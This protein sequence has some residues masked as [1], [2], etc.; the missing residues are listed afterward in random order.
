[1][2][3]TRRE[4]FDTLLAAA[5]AGATTFGTRP[6][7]A[8]TPA[9]RSPNETLRVGVIG[10]RGRGRAHIGAFKGMPNVEVAAICDADQSVVDQARKSV[11]DAVYHQDMR[12]LIEDD[13]LDI[14]AIATPNHWHSLATIWALQAGKHVYVEK[15][16]SHD[17]YEGRAVVEIA[18]ASG[19]V[20]QHGTQARTAKATR[21]AMQFLHEG[22]IGEVKLAR[23]LCYKRRGSI[24]QVGGAQEPP[25]S[26]D[27]KLWCGPAGMHPLTRRNLHYDWHWNFATGNGDLGN[28]G[29]HQMDI[30]RWGLGVDTLPTAIQSVGG[31]VGYV[32][33]GNTPNTQVSL[34]DYGA[35]QLIF[36]VRGLKTPGYK[37]ASIGV[38]FEGETGYLVSASYNK[39]QAFDHDGQ[40][41]ATFEGGE[42]HF[43][44]FIDAVRANDAA[45]VNASPLD[46]HLSSALC[47]LGNVSYLLGEAKPVGKL[48]DG[49]SGFPNGAGVEIGVEAMERFGKHLAENGV[50]LKKE[51]AAAGPLLT[52]DPASE[53]FT[54][55][56]ADEANA[57]LRKPTVDGFALPDLA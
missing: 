31:R 9:R 42:N 37:G 10:V 14:I 45:A 23:A 52:F 40:V 51:M 54:G 49:F 39:V 11:P 16:L 3:Q 27:Y 1:M 34:F 21:D 33:D 44:Q 26:C 38:V 50:D 15:P 8:R 30:A 48:A 56:H 24:G 57:L 32:D 4:F 5:A 46:G 47:H 25:A 29:V 20:V 2:T 18:K 7:I 36:E 12:A 35:Q 13:S 53:R 22:G 43:A 41:I 19:L 6:L 28:Q 55:A 17:V